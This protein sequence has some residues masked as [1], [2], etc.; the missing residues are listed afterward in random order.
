MSLDDEIRGLVAEQARRNLAAVE[1]ACE[2]ALVTEHCGVLVEHQADGS[3][4]CTVTSRVP[5]GWIHEHY[6]NR[7]EDR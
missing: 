5:W 4:V 6:R 2:E 1:R 7:T 3:V